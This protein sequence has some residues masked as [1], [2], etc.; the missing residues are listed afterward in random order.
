MQRIEGH[1]VWYPDAESLERLRRRYDSTRD[2]SKVPADFAT[3][4]P[5]VSNAIRELPRV[6]PSD[7]YLVR[8][9]VW[10]AA[11]LRMLAVSRDPALGIA[12]AG[13]E[14]FLHLLSL[15][16]D[17]DAV[18]ALRWL[19]DHVIQSL[20]KQRGEAEF[21]RFISAKER[22]RIDDLLLELTEATEPSM[23]LV[24][25]ASID[26]ARQLDSVHNPT[27]FPAI[28]AKLR[29]LCEVSGGGDER[30]QWAK[31]A[32]RYVHLQ[33][34]AISDRFG[35]LGLLDDIQVIEDVYE[36]ASGA[37]AW[38]RLAAHF[39]AE[40]PLLSNLYLR[41]GAT[42]YH[43]TNYLTCML[44]CAMTEA[45]TQ[46]GLTVVS[47]PDTGPLGYILSVVHALVAAEDKQE[48]TAP[49]PGT[50]VAFRVGN[51]TRYA[52]WDEPITIDDVRMPRVRLAKG[53]IFGFR[54]ELSQMLEL[55]VDGN[56][57]LATQK[58]FMHWADSV[59]E[60]DLVASRYRQPPHHSP[61]LIVSNHSRFAGAM[62][63]LHPF[64]RRLDELLAVEFLSRGYRRR[65]GNSASLAHPSI[66]VC[67]NLV[68]ALEVLQHAEESSVPSTIIVDKH[69][70]EDLVEH[71]LQIV[72]RL[73]PKPRIVLLSP[74]WDAPQ[75]CRRFSDAAIW[76]LT[77]RN[78]TPR[79]GMPDP[80]VTFER[81]TGALG[82]YTK[83]Q[84]LL[85]E[86]SY[87]LVEVACP[88]IDEFASVME[89]CRTI[90]SMESRADLDGLA[91]AGGVVLHLITQCSPVGPM[92]RNPR[93]I[94]SLEGL[95]RYI[96]QQ[97]SGDDVAS[98]LAVAATSLLS[99][100]SSPNPK[101]ETIRAE[102]CSVEGALIVVRS[103]D[104]AGTLNEQWQQD[105]ECLGA[106]PFRACSDIYRTDGATMLVVSGWHGRQ[107][108]Q[109]LALGG[110]APIVV[111][112]LFGF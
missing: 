57:R 4:W 9:W 44:G 14:L 34:D 51:K 61:V 13:I 15:P 83:R 58:E 1:G 86:V 2:T 48:F 21:N 95:A 73:E 82:S 5:Q 20:L 88:A 18:P 68:T 38:R 102:E 23:E 101:E 22:T 107:Q 98:R 84:A 62:A 77:Y 85:G 80:T 64:G 71:L 56:V 89:E 53:V 105:A 63:S 74:V 75:L 46:T 45:T 30:A 40:W 11:Q 31:A 52:I 55:A 81:A 50:A 35:Y 111:R 70:D 43:L 76:Y 47:S 29:H 19:T 28:A 3:V 37:S 97:M 112:V 65:R 60:E 66:R 100:L 78:V 33:D 12:W 93:L 24:R 94:R 104:T 106:G 32:L 99:F 7:L 96:G 103:R 59:T 67:G 6:A 72:T 27:Y 54:P 49:E 69:S 42:T 25:Q 10:I 87:R 39:K 26:M 92:D 36:L 16:A 79:L 41:D 17:A 8:S 109:R 110:W 108:M 91:I 90:C